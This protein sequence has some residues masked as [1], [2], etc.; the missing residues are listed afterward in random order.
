MNLRKLTR[1]TL[2]L[3]IGVLSFSCT[4][5]KP[6]PYNVLF[7]AVDDLNDWTAVFGGHPQTI[8]PNIDRLAAEGI[9]FQKAYCAASVCNPSRA[10][11]MSGIK[12]STSGIYQNNH[13]MRSSDVLAD[14]KTIPQWFSENG[15]FTTAKGKIFHHPNGKWA[16][17][18]SWDEWFHTTGNGMNKHPNW[19]K[20]QTAR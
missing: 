15:Y 20:Q 17:T 18:I 9:A 19:S 12:P 7:I 16:D 2:L 4:K 13:Y 11:I 5:E 6:Q 14:A 10:A 3:L 1:L 8:T